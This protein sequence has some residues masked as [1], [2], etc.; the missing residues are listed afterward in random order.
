MNS[1]PT[2]TLTD[3]SAAEQSDFFAAVQGDRSHGTTLRGENT[4]LRGENTTLRGENTILRDELTALR[5]ELTALR[6]DVSRME[7][8]MSRFQGDMGSLREEFLASREQLLPL[9]QQNETVR[10]TES[11]MD[12]AEVNMRQEAINKNMIAR[13]NNR[14]NGTIDALEPLHSLMTGREIEGVRS[15]AQ[16]EALLPRR[17]AEILSELGQPRQAFVNDRRRELRKLYGAGFLHLR[18]VREEDDD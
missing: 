17:M 16:L 13:L 7:Q 11:I 6:R 9:S 18:I 10:L 15:R 2:P 4:I 3:S 12:Q 5:D 1:N 14:L 8:A